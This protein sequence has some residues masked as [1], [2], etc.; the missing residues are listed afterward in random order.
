[1]HCLSYI[2]WYAFEN[3]IKT[4]FLFGC[5]Y[6]P[7][8]TSAVKQLIWNPVALTAWEIFLSPRINKWE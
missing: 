7:K 6:E 5:K 4:F 8:F 2:F 1:M 3:I